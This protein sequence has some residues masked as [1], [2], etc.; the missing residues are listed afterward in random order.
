MDIIH[1]II[2][3]NPINSQIQE[4]MQTKIKEVLEVFGK[5]YACKYKRN[6]NKR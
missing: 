6:N 5:N 1:K 2:P 3:K 4:K